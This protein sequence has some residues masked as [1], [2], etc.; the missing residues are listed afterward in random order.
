LK[1]AFKRLRRRETSG[2]KETKYAKDEN[3]NVCLDLNILLEKNRKHMGICPRV[4]FIIL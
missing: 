2:E 1:N 4:A 3:I